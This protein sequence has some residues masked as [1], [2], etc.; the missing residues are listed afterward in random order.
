M[1]G[2]CTVSRVACEYAVV[3]ATLASYP[4]QLRA[5]GES[6]QDRDHTVCE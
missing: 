5:Q 6:I 4:D 1:F 2:G 3:A